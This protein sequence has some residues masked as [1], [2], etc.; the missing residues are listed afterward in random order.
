ML[1][2]FS[3]FVLLAVALGVSACG[4]ASSSPTSPSTAGSTATTATISGT[5]QA[6]SPLLA[7]STGAAMS[8]VVVTIVGTNISAT[9]DAADR[10]T[11]NGVP[12]GDVTLK[13][14]GAGVDST[15]PLSQ[16]RPAE[17]V[18]LALSVAG[19][20]V[21]VDSEMRSTAS[22]QQLEGRVESLPPTTA[23]NTLTVAGKTVKTDSATRFEQGGA[24]KSFADL[25]IGMRVHVEGTAS[26]SDITASLIRIQ[27]TNTW[28]PVEVNGVIDSFTGTTAM[29]QFKIGSRQIKGDDL[30]VF[31]GNSTF[32]MLKDGVRV[33]VKGQQRDGYIYAERIHV[34]VDDDNDSGQDDSASIQG[35]VTAISGTKPNLTLTVGGTV[36]RTSGSTD[37]QRRGDMQT[38]D[39]LKVGQTLHVVGVRQ[40]NSSIDAR[41]IFIDDDAAGGEFEIQG[42]IGGLKGTCPSLTFGINGFAIATNGSTVYD[43]GAC[44]TLKNGD[45]VTVNGVKQ[46]DGSVLAKAIKK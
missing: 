23:A 35:V 7:A 29:F 28:I 34:N 6:G 43:G 16:L 25:L 18:S 8:G 14:S 31:F 2:S 20:S 36:V 32:S 44:S 26:G 1:K 22:S 15:V 11:L 41:H 9:V 33:E 24:T 19:A 39:A 17:T 21:S 5:V 4:G 3:F 38:L 30:T 42:S 10:F 27:N 40:S 12:P 37:V 13:F 45:K 46:A